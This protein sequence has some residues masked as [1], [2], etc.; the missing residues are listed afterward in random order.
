MSTWATVADVHTPESGDS[1]WASAPKSPSLLGQLLDAAEL[2]C[3]AFAP[4]PV[5][6]TDAEGVTSEV[7]TENMRLAVI[8][9]AR[10]LHAA[11]KREGDTIVQGDA[12]VVRARPLVGS[13]KQLL[14]PAR[15]RR[16]IG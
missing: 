12:Y 7:I 14:R 8:Y 15:G 6:V 3:R 11:S 5:L 10:E 13:V 2:Q 16:G 9:Q 4:L 1:P